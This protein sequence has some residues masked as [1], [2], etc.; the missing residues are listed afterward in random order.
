MLKAIPSFRLLAVAAVLT[1]GYAASA[2]SVILPPGGDNKKA[3]VSERIGI[4]DVTLQYHRPGV[5]GREGKIWGQLVAYGFTD[6]GF[7]P[8]KPAPWRAGANE[9]T[10]ISFTHDVKVEGKDLPAGTYGLHLALEPAAC[11]VI[12]SKNST[13]WG[14]YFYDSAEDALRVNVKPTPTDQSQEWLTY[15]FTEQTPNSAVVALTWEKLKIPFKV[16]VDVPKTVVESLRRELR[17]SPGFD[18]QNWNAAAAYCLQNNVNY[19]EALGWAEKAVGEPFIGQANFTTL[20]TKAQLLEKLSKPAEADAAMQQALDKATPPQIHGYGR[21][22]LGQNRPK[23]AL[24][25]FELNAKRNGKAWPVNV[26]LA[27]G[28]AAVGDT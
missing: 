14:S 10:T 1:G 3:S 19:E 25:V 28:Y 22:L 15:A 4:T 24:A 6:L 21:Q 5:K 23:E 20:S 9:N 18:W 16:E 11:T 8:G 27:R 7:G 17:N 2:Q 13:S 26:G 12:F